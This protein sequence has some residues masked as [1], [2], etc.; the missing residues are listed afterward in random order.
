MLWSVGSLWKW[1]GWL[2]CIMRALGKLGGFCIMGGGNWVQV[3]GSC[4]TFFPFGFGYQN[5]RELEK[6]SPE[7]GISWSH[8][9][10]WVPKSSSLCIT[11]KLGN[12]HPKHKPKSKQICVPGHHW[13]MFKGFFFLASQRAIQRTVQVCWEDTMSPCCCKLFRA[14]LS[15]KQRAE[16]VIF[17]QRWQAAV[18][19]TAQLCRHLEKAPL[20]TLKWRGPL[21]WL[22]YLELFL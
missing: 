21:S 8:L 2:L 10:L 14:L 11:I 16:L 3:N 1:G 12:E 19:C 18:C 7:H 9:A 13:G 17:Q 6:A 4:W 15:K 22:G 20:G 5:R